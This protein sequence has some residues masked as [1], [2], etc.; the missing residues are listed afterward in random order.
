M[1]KGFWGTSHRDSAAVAEV[2]D[3]LMEVVYG[4]PDTR[5]KFEDVDEKSDDDD[6]QTAQERDGTGEGMANAR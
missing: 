4:S 5:L 3:N 2:T 1:C 6:T